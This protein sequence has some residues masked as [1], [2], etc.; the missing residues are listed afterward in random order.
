MYRGEI[1]TVAYQ[2]PV[3]VRYTTRNGT[4]SVPLTIISSL[5]IHSTVIGKYDVQNCISYLALWGNVDKIIQMLEF[6][7]VYCAVHVVL[8]ATQ[9]QKHT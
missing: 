9:E 4:N 2:I 7:F 8:M 6:L 5:R 3:S 1:A